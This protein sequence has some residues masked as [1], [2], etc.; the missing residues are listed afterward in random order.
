MILFQKYEHFSINLILKYLLKL[1]KI[2]THHLLMKYFIEI[3]YVYE[4]HQ[5]EFFKERQ[6]KIVL[7]NFYFFDYFTYEIVI[8][9]MDYFHVHL[10]FVSFFIF[11]E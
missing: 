2:I 9:G 11:Q 6:R 4:L 8:F 10:H 5:N 7:L 1:K 3:L